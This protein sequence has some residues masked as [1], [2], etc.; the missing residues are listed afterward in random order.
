[1]TVH[2]PASRLSQQRSLFGRRRPPETTARPIRLP[3][4]VLALLLALLPVCGRAAA[5][6]LAAPNAWAVTVND[7]LDVWK[8]GGGSEVTVVY[9]DS[10]DQALD[11]EMGGQTFDL[12]VAGDPHAFNRAMSRGGLAAIRS[13]ASSPLVLVVSDRDKGLAPSL[14]DGFASALGD[15][16]LA[17]GDP[18]SD[19]VGAAARDLL[20]QAGLWED[21]Q[22]HLLILPG[23][24]GVVRAVQS[25][26]ARFGIALHSDLV[27]ASG[28]HE[29]SSLGSG[30]PPEYTYSVALV[31]GHL[32][33]EVKRFLDFLQ[34]PAAAHTFVAH[35]FVARNGN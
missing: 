20:N 18:Q 17:V 6:V 34:S 11:I 14:D 12:L 27:R 5:I 33:P 15:G 7:L 35:G 2:M 21:L 29:G 25:G 23:S 8:T 32:R 1:M 22:D 31:T 16:R 28:V 26:D 4:V 30:T 3:L 24:R 19:G 9:G 13:L 10:D